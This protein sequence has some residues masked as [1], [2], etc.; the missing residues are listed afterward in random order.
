[1]S[2]IY[3]LKQYLKNLS[4]QIRNAKK[5]LKEFQKNNS[6]WDN[7]RFYIL[8]NLAKDYR[9][10]HIVYCLLRGKVYEQIERKCNEINKLD[11][12]FIQE[13]K[14]AYKEDVCFSTQ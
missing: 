3:E 12:D 13:I 5:E 14:D 4:L 9:Y 6:G 8:K 10:H 7:G 11:M 1:M 2:K